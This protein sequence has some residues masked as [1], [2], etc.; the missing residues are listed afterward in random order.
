MIYALHLHAQ[1]AAFFL[2][3]MLVLI[4]VVCLLAEKEERKQNAGCPPCNHNCNEG[5]DCPRRVK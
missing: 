1:D 4:V 5:R 2:L 3:A